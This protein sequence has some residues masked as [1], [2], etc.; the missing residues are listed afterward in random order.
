MIFKIYFLTFIIYSFVGWIME[1]LFCFFVTKKMVNRGFLIGPICP[2]YGV[3][4]MLLI[5]LLNK[6]IN[7]PIAL[8]ALSIIVCSILEYF[9]SYIMEKL[10]KVRW[11]DYSDK[12]FNI[13]G[14]ICLETMVPFGILGTLIVCYINPFLNNLL[15]QCNGSVINWFFYI[16]FIL[17]I[18]DLII[19]LKVVTNIKVITSNVL[20]DNTEEI[21]NKFKDVLM[22]KIKAIKGNK[23][24]VNKKIKS[25]LTSESYFTKRFVNSF[26]K[27]KVMN[28]IKIERKNK[29]VK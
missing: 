19:S 5:F 26:P 1:T 16:V 27:F 28:K 2:I 15:M 14:R 20:K 11:W 22:N 18:E 7:Q 24:S 6:Y 12:K 3:G 21:N 29:N 23:D 10:F 13:N 4:C 9:T 25:I 17:F 8:F